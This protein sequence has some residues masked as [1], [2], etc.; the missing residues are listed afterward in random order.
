MLDSLG[1]IREVL[2]QGTS[3]FSV[4]FGI[5]SRIA[6]ND[7]VV[8]VQESP[9]DVLCDGQ[10]FNFGETYCQITLLKGDVVAIEEM[11]S[12]EYRGHPCYEMFMLQT[13]IGVPL[14][15]GDKVFGTLNFSSPIPFGRK[16]NSEDFAFIRELASQ[17]EKSEWIAQQGG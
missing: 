17:I 6:E 1:D 5:V 8:L 2:R 16:F 3:H 15:V 13:Y 11:S 10:R 12:S 7:Y 9:D 4:E 14:R